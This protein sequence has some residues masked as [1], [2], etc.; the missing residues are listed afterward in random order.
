MVVHAAGACVG[1]L[2]LFKDIGG[3]DPRTGLTFQK[4]HAEVAVKCLDSNKLT[5]GYDDITLGIYNKV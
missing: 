2:V 5:F 4:C 3:V 1:A